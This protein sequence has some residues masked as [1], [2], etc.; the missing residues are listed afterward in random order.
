MRSVKSLL[1]SAAA[2]L[3]CINSIASSYSLGI[4]SQSK[5]VQEIIDNEKKVGYKFPVVA[6]VLDD[7]MLQGSL[8]VRNIA[9]KLGTGR[10]YHITLSPENLSA[11]QVARSGFDEQYLAFFKDVKKYK[12]KVLFRTMHEMNGGRYSR[13]G[14]PENFKKARK[15]IHELSRQ[16]GLDE[17]QIQFIFSFNRHDMPVAGGKKPSQT[18]SY[19]T[20]TPEKKASI[21]C[22]TREDYYPGKEYVDIIGFTAYNWGKATSN[23]R[24]LTMEQTIHDPSRDNWSRV[25]KMK[26]PLYIDE[27][28]T[29]A[30]K[31]GEMF[32]RSK[33]QDM[34][35][36]STIPKSERLM[37]LSHLVKDMPQIIGMNY[38]NVDYTNGLRHHLLGEADWKIID[39]EKGM[40]YP[41]G[42]DLIK[43]ND[44]LTIEMVFSHK[45]QVV[46]SKTNKSTS[47][48]L[49][50]RARQIQ[51][52]QNHLSAQ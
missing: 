6:F 24:R 19:I 52:T 1:F 29:T 31:Y 2:L 23:R 26:K 7:Y 13:S 15:N 28:G 35:G 33:S 5:T 44:P 36:R 25:L 41:G 12:L 48:K 16:A 50:K 14:D 38:F 22:L 45:Q 8:V 18:A 11:S 40:M 37:D 30:I 27:V 17:T 51:P 4:F 42:R 49:A 10:I 9:N 20:C 3:L 47:K 21:G 39:P 32:D 46:A 43:N 34:Y